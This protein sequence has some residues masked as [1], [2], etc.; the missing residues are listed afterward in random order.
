MDRGVEYWLDDSSPRGRFF[1]LGGSSLRSV[2]ETLGV[3]CFSVF[4]DGLLDDVSDGVDLVPLEPRDESVVDEAV[5]GSDP[6]ESGVA[7]ATP[8]P[9]ATAAPIPSAI[10]SPP[11]R[12]T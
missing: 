9:V 2:S 11:T 5:D 3:F 6:D 1:R 12:P 4:D 10:A 8:C 7:E